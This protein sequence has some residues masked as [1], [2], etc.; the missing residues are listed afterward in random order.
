MTDEQKIKDIPAEKFRFVR[1]DERI[2]DEKL[3]TK[4]IG[5]FKDAWLRFSKI[6][7]NLFIAFCT[8]FKSFN[9]SSFSCNVLFPFITYNMLTVRVL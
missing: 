8:S 5:Y 3:K 1:S 4:P 7:L 6:F 9:Y 2:H